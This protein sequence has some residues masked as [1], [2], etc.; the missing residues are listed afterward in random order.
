MDTVRLV[1]SAIRSL[2][3]VA[4]GALAAELRAVLAREDDYAAAG[5]PVCDYD[6]EAARV[7]LVEEQWYP[8]NEQLLEHLPV[9]EKMAT[10]GSVRVEK[11]GSRL[12]WATQIYVAHGD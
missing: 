12:C 8:V 3:K 5:K 6:D 1:R 2:I 4:D 11:R 10:A 7:E 9:L